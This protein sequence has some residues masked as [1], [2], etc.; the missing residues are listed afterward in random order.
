MCAAGAVDRPGQARRDTQLDAWVADG[1]E[2][3]FTFADQVLPS[4][5]T[6]SA[7]I[8]YARWYLT[9]G[10]EGK[11]PQGRIR[12]MY[13]M[14]RKGFGVPEEERIQLGRN[15]WK[16]ITED[17]LSIGVV[18][19]SPVSQGT[20]VAKNNLGNVPARMYNS[21]DGRTPAITR[22]MTLFFKN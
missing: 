8:L 9:N 4:T 2:H 3:M 10:R 6:T 12:E 15:V 1:S 5:I 20:R 21:A 18:G 16:I 7:G 19:L 13:D 11:E 17:V 22:P 14:F